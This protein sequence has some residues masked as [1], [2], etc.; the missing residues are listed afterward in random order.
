[1]PPMINAF[2]KAASP[3]SNPGGKSPTNLPS[4]R[5]LL[6]PVDGVSRSASSS[7][8]SSSR[9]AT[10]PSSTV[11]LASGLHR[12]PSD[13]ERAKRPVFGNVTVSS[14]VRVFNGRGAQAEWRFQR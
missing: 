5:R 11:G 9:R 6:E 12:L 14:A 2:L 7:R 3:T 13:G 1:M 10:S 4:G 8:R